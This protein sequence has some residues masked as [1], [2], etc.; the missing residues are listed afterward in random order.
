[1]KKNASVLKRIIGYIKRYLPLVGV[2]LLLNLAAVFAE[3]YIP[4]LV[5][6]A[7]DKML[8]K[9]QVDFAAIKTILFAVGGIA[10]AG[11]A[12]QYAIAAINNRLAFFV[13]RDLR[14][15]LIVKLQKLPLSALDN[16][17][18]GKLVSNMINDA[19]T[20]AD[21]VLLGFT[22]LFNG[23]ITV[24]ATIGFMLYYNRIITLVVVLVTPIS[25]FV[26][27]FIA[28]RT[29]KKFT[30][31]AKL[32]AEQTAFIDEMV[33]NQ[34]T[35]KAYSYEE[36][37][38][39]RFDELNSRLEKVSSQAVF[40]S[41]LTN[42]FTRCIN[43]FVYALVAL[44]G[45]LAA[46]GIISVGGGLTAGGL[47][48]LLSYSNKYT[49]PFNE[50]SGVVTELQSSL[51]GAS[52]IFALLDAEEEVSDENN[53]TLTDI[54]GKVS[55]ND[56][57]FSYVP[58]KKLIEHFSLEVA[59]GERIAIVGPTGCGKTTFINL[60]MRFYDVDSGSIKIDDKDIRNVTRRSLRDAYGMVLQE[61]WIRH[62]TVRENLIFGN[63]ATEKEMLDAAEKC[64]CDAFI[65]RL[66]Q[67][68]DTVLTE[69]ALSQG[70]KQL[71]CI[72][73]VML[74]KPKMLI[75]DEA[76]SSVD[77]RTEVRINKAFDMLMEGKTSFVVAHRLSTIVNSDKIVV[78]KSGKVVEVGA[79]KD[80]LAKGGFYADL[81]YGRLH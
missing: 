80:L 48:C 38:A 44:T 61:T 60:L 10:I 8:G 21:G 19:E 25:L 3:L 5:G 27:K 67:G 56:V 64:H 46:C 39:E 51:V 65:R 68:Y 7:I 74:S 17:P 53:E 75:L 78:M 9:N 58:E 81:F 11:G 73:R 26:A 69:D 45:G 28:T 30:E 40:F 42:P 13:V 72:A 57:F 62:A 55:I 49:K 22:Q 29:H 52:R 23:V 54:Q 33:I 41:S 77:T 37:S 2:I 71:L 31:Q 20:V 24:L 14:N 1:M 47:S 34:K 4:V 79:H 70:E 12:I 43:S 18:T 6:R 36:K 35:V 59:P 16:K 15:D 66:P 32:K 50:I 63:D 76:T